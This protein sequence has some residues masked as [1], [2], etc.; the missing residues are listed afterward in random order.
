MQFFIKQLAFLQSAVALR[1]NVYVF[2]IGGIMRSVFL[3]F[4]LSLSGCASWSESMDSNEVSSNNDAFVYGRFQ[5]D[6]PKAFL[7]LDG[8]NTIGMS[9]ACNDGKKYTIRFEREPL[10]QVFRFTP[11]TCSLSEFIFTDADGFIRGRNRLEGELFKT[12]ALESGMAY[13]LGDYTAK[14]TV[15]P[16]YSAARIEWEID[17]VSDNFVDTSAELRARY[18]NI[19]EVDLT[20]LLRGHSN[21]K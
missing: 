2:S 21:F 7:G 5:I 12:V 1:L 14:T 10:V 8:H 3:V 6:T 16:L 18:P 11:A 19:S 9:F 15:I 13:Y 4:C 17:S 20:N